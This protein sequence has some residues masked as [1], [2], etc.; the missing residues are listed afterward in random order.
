MLAVLTLPV[1]VMLLWFFAGLPISS[2]VLIAFL[3]S[4]VRRLRQSGEARNPRAS[5]RL[6][7]AA[8]GAISAP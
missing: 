1:T 5:G 8:P 4:L 6:V 3:A 2:F 7:P